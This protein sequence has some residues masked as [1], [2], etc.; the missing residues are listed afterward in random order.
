MLQNKAKL[1]DAEAS[2]QF[3]FYDKEINKANGQTFLA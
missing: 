2:L 3:L 1:S